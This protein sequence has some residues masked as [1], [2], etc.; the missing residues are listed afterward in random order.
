MWE[1]DVTGCVLHETK[2]RLVVVER[3]S[4]GHLTEDWQCAGSTSFPRLTFQHLSS[5]TLSLMG[6]TLKSVTGECVVR[7]DELQNFT[8]SSVT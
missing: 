4:Q 6:L 7:A 8:S 2:P 5:A 3:F 1:D